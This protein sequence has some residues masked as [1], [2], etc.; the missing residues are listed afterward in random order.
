MRARALPELVPPPANA[1]TEL[2]ME[3]KLAV[4]AQGVPVWRVW[5]RRSA[6]TE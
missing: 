1:V 3:A 4:V 2:T 5:N 6:T